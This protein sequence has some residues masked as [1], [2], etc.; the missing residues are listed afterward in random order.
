MFGCML[1][2]DECADVRSSREERERW[3]VHDAPLSKRRPG[4]FLRRVEPHER[5]TRFPDA[6]LPEFP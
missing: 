5:S 1:V 4:R 2:S 6:R 3:K